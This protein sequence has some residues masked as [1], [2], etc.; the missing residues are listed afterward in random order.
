[1]PNVQAG[2]DVG[3]P[4]DPATWPADTVVLRCGS[5]QGIQ[6]LTERLSREALARWIVVGLHRA[7]CPSLR[8]GTFLRQQPGQTNNGGR[9]SAGRWTAPALAWPS[10]S[11]RPL[12]PD[13]AGVRCDPQR[14]GAQSGAETGSVEALMITL[15]ADFNHMDAQGRL[16]LDDLRMHQQS[17]RPA[18]P[19]F[20][21]TTG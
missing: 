4:N 7:R 5:A 8:T 14:T 17:K 15:Q 12:W 2:P 1:V 3:D 16:R 10:T 9:D 6:E 20:Q 21:S 11:P 18:C 13:P 19:C